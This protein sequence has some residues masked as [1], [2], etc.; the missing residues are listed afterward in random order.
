MIEEAV[1][2][3]RFNWWL[4]LYVAAGACVVFSLLVIWSLEIG[5]IL[6]CIG[7]LLVGWLMFALAT[8]RK[9]HQR[10]SVLLAAV[11]YLA[12]SWALVK[13]A[14]EVR[15]EGRWMLWSGEYKFQI[16]AQPASTDGELKHVEWDGWGFAGNETEAY[17]V[18][19]PNDSLAP[20]VKAHSSG[21]FS[22]IPCEVW[23]V[24]RFQKHWYSVT[25][26]TETAWDDCNP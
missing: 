14:F 17:L 4:P 19:D 9:G 24:H 12:V 10:L 8:D 20:E 21:K 7:A 25:F 1:K 5:T 13:H 16:L 3:D 18:F 22:G 2:E 11:V 6:Y 23:N 15:D 26:Y